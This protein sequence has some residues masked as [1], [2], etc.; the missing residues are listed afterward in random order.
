MN[1]NHIPIDGSVPTHVSSTTD[2]ATIQFEAPGNLE[3]VL[4]RPDTWKKRGMLEG[5][6]R[7]TERDRWYD[8]AG[9]QVDHWK[10][11]RGSV[12]STLVRRV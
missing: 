5:G 6:E 2:P 8:G 11:G 12:R 3:L 1:R 9:E 10:P 7:R 4:S